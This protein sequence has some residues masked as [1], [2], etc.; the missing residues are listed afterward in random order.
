M[1]GTFANL[2][3][4]DLSENTAGDYTGLLLCD[5]GAEVIK[6]IPTNTPSSIIEND[7][8]FFNRGKKS[9]TLNMDSKNGIESLHALI[10]SADIVI[11]TKLI[12]EATKLKLNYEDIAALNE[13]LIYCS[14]PPYGDTGPMANIPGDD[15]TIGTYTGVHEGQGGETGTPQ[16]VQVPLV[17][18]GT[19]FTASLAIAAALLERE[20]SGQGQKVEVSMYAGSAAMQ[21]TSF[22]DGEE[23]T[24]RIRVGGGKRGLPVYR[25]F[26][27][28]DSWLFMA[29]GNNVFWNKLCIALELYDLLDDERFA[30]APWGIPMEHW[31]ELSDLIEPKFASNTREYWLKLLTE[32]DIPCGPAE[33]RKWFETHPQVIHN[34]MLLDINDP[35]LGQTRQ[36][37]PPIRFTESN[38]NAQGAAPLPGDDNNIL[39]TLI[40]KSTSIKKT[41]NPLSHPLEGIKVVDLTGYI[42]GAYGT[43]MLADLGADVLKVESFAGDGFRQNGA[44]FQ[45]WNQGKRGAI[46]N[47]KHPEG[48]EI[49]HQLVRDADV[50]TENFRGGIA[51]KLSVDYKSLR[52]INSNII[53]STVNGYGLTG[54]YSNYP[55]FDPLIQAQG[56]LMR[57]QGGDGAPIFL[58]LAASDYSSAILSAY[59]IVAA[60]YYRKLHNIGQHVE[61]SLVNSA[62]A[63]QAAEYFSYPNKPLQK[64]VG[65]VGKSADYRLYQ[66]KNGWVFISCKQSS[67]WLKLCDAINRP[68][69]QQYE[70]IGKRQNEDSYLNNV[71]EQIF[72]QKELNEWLNILR[73]TKVMCAPNQSITGLHDDP[74]AQAI[75]ITTE[76]NTFNLG[77]IRLQGLPFKFSRTPG[78][79]DLPAP[80]HGEHTDQVLSEL[81]FASIKIKDLRNRGI[82]G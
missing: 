38:S 25:L 49:F 58:R 80:A 82:I 13:S 76:T 78:K 22:I 79:L 73:K 8:R 75:G 27:C 72:M 67:E 33:T 50:V 14:I 5:M 60:L 62:F 74:Q 48:M 66:T 7:S 56:G 16:Y 19:A 39:K 30:N 54:P 29:C 47:L 42:A 21:A 63:Y 68:D 6:I 4:I 35:I 34:Q 11:S 12:A 52:K 15:G 31:D 69:L 26:E 77:N 28:N 24:K 40:P 1:S 3:V 17:S 81:G 43:T 70:N 32:N 53:Y 61:I 9:V 37:A 41:M 65:T 2:R 64:R 18:Y 55:A 57:D 51:E 44:A 45:G 46:I 23:V 36:P 10:A 59:G 20:S 71:L